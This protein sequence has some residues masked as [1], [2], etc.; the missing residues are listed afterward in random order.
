MLIARITPKGGGFQ[1]C[2]DYLDLRALYYSLHE[3]CPTESGGDRYPESLV[4]ELAYEVRKAKDGARETVKA[5]TFG[6]GASA[7]TYHAVTLSLP[8]AMIQYAFAARLLRQSKKPL[9]TERAHIAA[10]GAAVVS[11]LDQLKIKGADKLLE[12]V[13]ASVGDWRGWPDDYLV[14]VIDRTH[15]FD[16]KSRRARVSD[17][18]LLP[19]FLRE[20]GPFAGAVMEVRRE[21]AAKHGVPVHQVQP[22]QP[23]GEP[24]M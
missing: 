20:D 9:L 1:L 16:K 3:I 12:K 13:V 15:L 4:Y 22:V 8:R 10:F 5:A 24:E 18:K 11:A 19:E 7:A 14:E 17:L 21:Y 2:G 6:S 23:E